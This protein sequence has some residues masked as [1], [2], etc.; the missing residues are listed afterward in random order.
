M[1]VL[2][3][4]RPWLYVLWIVLGILL[5]ALY[6]L[7]SK[8][9]ISLGVFISPAYGKVVVIDAGHGGFDS[10]A[11]SSSGVREDEINLKLAKKLEQHLEHEGV[12]VVMTRNDSKAIGRTKQE[13]MN[14]RVQI[15]RDSNPDIVVSI[16]LNHFS[17]SRYYGAQTF[18]MEGSQ[19]GKKL[20]QCIQSQL[21]RILDRGNRR[22]IK[23][24]SS[25]RILKASE[26][27]SVI[28]ECG[29]LSNPEE[30]ELLETDDYQEQVS[31][32]IYSG[33]IQYFSGK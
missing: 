19:E 23:A 13:D 26:A 21:I 33:I 18:Y 3:I 9:D 29:F 2:Y 32:A 17:Q 27:P 20:A 15:I 8:E 10:G 25:L 24:V 11:V 30:T 7:K 1:R 6:C 4:R 31:W 16:H 5:A 12:Q 28:V 22:Q 14:K